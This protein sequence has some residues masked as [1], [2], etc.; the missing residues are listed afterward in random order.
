MTT[1]AVPKL[2]EL[3]TSLRPDNSVVVRMTGHGENG[4]LAVTDAVTLPRLQS[5]RLSALTVHGAYRCG[6]ADA[7]VGCAAHRPDDL[8]PLALRKVSA[9]SKLKEAAKGT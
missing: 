8:G 9:G 2:G 6:T 1:L 4:G 5:I 3:L 7:V